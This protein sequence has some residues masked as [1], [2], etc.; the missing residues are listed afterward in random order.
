[1]MIQRII[2]SSGEQLPVIGLGTWQRFDVDPHSDLSALINVLQVFHDAG[3]RL[4][5]SSPMYRRS[6]EVIGKLT[7]A[8]PEQDQFFYATKV[9]TEGET[10]GVRQMDASFSKMKRKVIDLMQI[11]NLVDWKTHLKTLRRWKEEGRVRYIGITHYTNSMHNELAR[12]LKQEKLDF[13]QFNY[14]IFDRQAEEM[15]LPLAQDLGV[16]VLIN[17]PLD[18][19]SSFEHVK[20][21]SLPTWAAELEMNSWSQFFVKYIISHPAVTCVIPATGNP[22]HMKDNV[23][24]GI[25]PLPDEKTR[26]KM[27]EWVMQ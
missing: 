10:A 14:S 26:K 18:V 24:A 5:D 17:R 7:E 2:P 21:L 25:G 9:W 15:L 13:V 12:V 1:M 3:G 8:M 16:A 19:G 22:A 23:A 27:V 20:N 4:I 11:H 6:E